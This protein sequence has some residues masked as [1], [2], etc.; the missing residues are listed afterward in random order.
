MRLL[1]LIRFPIGIFKN[2]ILK[3]EVFYYGGF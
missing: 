1:K 3:E 2:E